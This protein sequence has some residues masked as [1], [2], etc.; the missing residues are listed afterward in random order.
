MT[1]KAWLS[2]LLL[3]YMAMFAEDTESIC[4]SKTPLTCDSSHFS[5]TLSKDSPLI[6]P[7]LMDERTFLLKRSLSAMRSL[8]ASLFRGSLA[9][10]SRKRNCKPTTTALRLRTG[11][12]SSVDLLFALDL[13]RL[14][15]EVL[16]DGE[17][18]VELAAFVEALVGRDGE[19]E[20]EDIVR[21]WE[22]GLH[23]A[24]E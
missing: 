13:R 5:I 1:H 22:G 18:E 17:G 10:G 11:F 14:V 3:I 12:Q 6:W 24:R 8:A 23:G 16:A 9:L 2:Y 21:V 20:I 4:P 19:G 7:P 15:R